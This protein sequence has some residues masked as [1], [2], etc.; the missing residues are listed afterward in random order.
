MLKINGVSPFF[1]TQDANETF[2]SERNLPDELVLQDEHQDDVIKS[3]QMR[4]G[5]GELFKI[6]GSRDFHMMFT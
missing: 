3:K 6:T 4:Y 5:E 1:N 2:K